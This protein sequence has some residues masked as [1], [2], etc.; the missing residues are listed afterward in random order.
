MQPDSI[1]TWDPGRSGSLHLNKHTAERIVAAMVADVN[2]TDDDGKSRGSRTELDTHAN[3]P[4]V[5]KHSYV[6]CDSGRTVDVSPYTPD[7]PSMS[8]KVVDAAVQYDCPYDGATRVFI[9]R[10]AVHVPSMENN[11]V[12]PFIMREAGVKVNDMPKIQAEE[13]TVEHHSL[14]FPETSF[15]V[16]LKLWGIFSYFPSSKPSVGVLEQSKEVYT[17]TPDSFNPH[18]KAYAENEENM[19]D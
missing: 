18:D 19:L 5:G 15:R 17:L 4:V 13:P 7:Y 8:L 6:V 3:M 12:P 1:K 9:I 11:L 2:E 10:N 14:Y 16:P